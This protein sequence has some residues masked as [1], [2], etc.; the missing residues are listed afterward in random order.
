MGNEPKIIDIEPT[1]GCN[2]RC[3]MCHVSFMKEPVEFLDLDGISDFSFLKGKT[4]L[5]GSV[6]EPLIHPDINKLI[7]ILNQHDCRLVLTTNAHNL[8]KKEI[9]AIYDS[10]IESVTFSFDGI[11]KDIYEQIR[12]GG[13]F[14]RTLENIAGFID[15]CNG[16]KTLFAINFTAMSCNL[17]EVSKA[18]AF[19]EKYNIDLI[20][21]ITMVIRNKNDFLEGNS[22]WSKRELYF[23][24]LSKA[25]SAID[26]N[27]YK[28]SIASP[29]FESREVKLKFGNR[30]S[31]GTFWSRCSSKREIR[32]HNKFEYGAGFGMPFPCKSPFV[33]A[34][35]TWDG[36]VNLCHRM[37]VGN[38]YQQNFEEI[39][40]GKQADVL[41][42][43]LIDG[44]DM[45]YECDYYKFCIKSPVVDLNDRS[46]YYSQDMLSYM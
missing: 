40:N 36:T 26:E 25:A 6:F 8:H 33:A 34:Q 13:N 19:W 2:L 18:P 14:D 10:N 43:Q 20:R 21:Y 29:Y 11:S 38:L 15:A 45:C 3:R 4:V 16:D 39:W 12:I 44:S 27:D 7:D 46:N 24:E 1:K 9:P 42:N 31:S 32:N 30:I 35:I 41:R 17:D 23:Q 5:L 37:P 22:L 28:I